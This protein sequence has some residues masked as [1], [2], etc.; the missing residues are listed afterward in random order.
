MWLLTFKTNTRHKRKRAEPFVKLAGHQTFATSVHTARDAAAA[1]AA[2]VVEP[3]TRTAHKRLGAG[4]A[5]AHRSVAGQTRAGSLILHDVRAFGQRQ[6]IAAR[7]AGAG[8]EKAGTLFGIGGGVVVDAIESGAQTL[9]RIDHQLAVVI[10]VG[11]TVGHAHQPKAA[12]E[13]DVRGGQ[14][15]RGCTLMTS[16]HVGRFEWAARDAVI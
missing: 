12:D 8:A 15:R 9:G 6:T 4:R 14:W 11:Q 16:E 5:A 2:A 3:P 13:S 10:F 1:A 7:I